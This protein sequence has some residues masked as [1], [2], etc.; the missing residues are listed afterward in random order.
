MTSMSDTVKE[1]PRGNS[2]IFRRL[3]CILGLHH[4]HPIWTNYANVHPEGYR[5]DWHQYCYFCPAERDNPIH[6]RY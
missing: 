5:I 4:W 1:K 6:D 2:N 3:L